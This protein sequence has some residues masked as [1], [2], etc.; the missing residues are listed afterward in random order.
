MVAASAAVIAP[1]FKVIV[2]SAEKKARI[3]NTKRGGIMKRM[4]LFA[5]MVAVVSVMSLNVLA[6]GKAA[7]LDQRTEVFIDA[8]DIAPA[9]MRS[10]TPCCG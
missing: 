6:F 2:G 3:M 9:D 5:V 10:D 7:S 8:V 1:S 4:G